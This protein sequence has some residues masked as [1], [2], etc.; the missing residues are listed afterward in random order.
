MH[1]FVCINTVVILFWASWT[2]VYKYIIS[3]SP[4]S[5]QHTL[6]SP[7]CP[8]WM[9]KCIITSLES[10]QSHDTVWLQDYPPP[11][12]FSACPDFLRHCNQFASLWCVMSWC[13]CTGPRQQCLMRCYVCIQRLCCTSKWIE[14]AQQTFYLPLWHQFVKILLSL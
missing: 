12:A 1:T 3:F 8:R 9:S 2:E 6:L 14:R 10:I 11:P 5:S 7:C 13:I 4:P